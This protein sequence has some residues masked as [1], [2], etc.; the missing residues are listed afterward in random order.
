M[1][2]GIIFI[3]GGFIF[4]LLWVFILKPLIVFIRKH[5]KKKRKSD[6]SDY[7]KKYINK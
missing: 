7:Y 1:D 5:I 4:T 2:I 6:I 3:F